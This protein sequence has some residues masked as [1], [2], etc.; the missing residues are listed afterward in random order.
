MCYKLIDKTKHRPI[1]PHL[2]GAGKRLTKISVPFLILAVLV[3]VP[4]F[5]AQSNTQFMYG[6]GGLAATTRA[7]RDTAAIEEQFGKENTLVLLVSKGDAGQEAELCD[8][9]SQI[10]HVT[11]VASYVTAVGPE[12]PPEYIDED[13]VEQF[14]SAN[15]ARIIL[16]TDLEEEGT[17]TFT[18]VQSILDTARGSM[19]TIIW[20]GR[21]PRC[22]I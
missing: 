11:D 21:G 6:M 19:T 2:K 4:C 5:L 22:T 17:E 8:A 16:Y 10:P 3:A 15:Y 7:G 12:I 20:P 18:A 9:L 1:I 13:I 14:Y